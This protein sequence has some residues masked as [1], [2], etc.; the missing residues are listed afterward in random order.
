MKVDE[1]VVK[2]LGYLCRSY[3]GITQLGTKTKQRLIA[4]MPEAEAIHQDEII[5][6]EKIKDRLNREINKELKF[7]PVWEQWLNHVKGIGPFIAG[8]LILLYYYRFVAICTKCGGDLEKIEGAMKCKYCGS[9]SKGD[10]VLK[11]RIDDK[12][13]ATISKWWKY[14]GRHTGPDGKMPRKKK[15]IICDWSPKGRL[16]GYHI[17]EQFNRQ[18]DKHPYKALV[19]AEKKRLEGREGL[20][21][22]HIQ[23]MALNKAVKLF[24]SHFW[25]VA[26]EIEGK[27]MTR[28]Y[29]ETILGHENIIDPFYWDR[30][31][32]EKAA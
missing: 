24:L 30:D 18:N 8:N 4:M 21:K 20:T 2:R 19:L 25:M 29:A 15:G 10:G 5:M 28:P 6:M 1:R 27:A 9:M 16:I 11:H 17:G 26:H 22:L 7:F 14:M 12:E 32:L 31:K 13:F 23:R 3:D